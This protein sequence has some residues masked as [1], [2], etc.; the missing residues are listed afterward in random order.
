MLFLRPRFGKKENLS[1]CTVNLF[2]PLPMFT[3][4]GRR[5]FA[6]R[7]RG[8]A[9]CQFFFPNSRI[10]A[11]HP[12]AQRASLAPLGPESGWAREKNYRPGRSSRLSSPAATLK[13]TWPCRLRGCN[14][15]E[16][17][18]PPTST[19]PPAPTPIVALP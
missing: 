9:R 18:E 6:G 10:E 11:P 17:L 3:G 8:E 16:L 15:I 7:V 5:V 14:A 12:N 2:Q 1:Q 13:P 4:R 19:L